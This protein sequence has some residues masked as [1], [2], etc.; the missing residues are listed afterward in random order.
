MSEQLDKLA[1]RLYC[2]ETQNDL[3][4]RDF[5]EE[6]SERVKEEYRDKAKRIL[7][8]ERWPE[9]GNKA[10][11]IKGERI[12]SRTDNLRK[13]IWYAGHNKVKSVTVTQLTPRQ[14]S[15]SDPNARLFIEFADGAMGGSDFAS[16]QVCVSFV[17]ER[18]RKW[19]G[20]RKPIFRTV[21]AQREKL[22]Q[23][24]E[25]RYCIRIHE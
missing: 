13:L 8:F 23:Y 22:R 21:T 6:L 17:A 7:V 1:W 11:I 10:Y 24:T 3:D 20:D 19:M 16:F 14:T 5:W 2:E 4:V 12:V 18:L 15:F 25:E 9:I